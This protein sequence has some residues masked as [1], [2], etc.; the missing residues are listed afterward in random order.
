MVASVASGVY[1]SGKMIPPEKSTFS[2]W[3]WGSKAGATKYDGYDP[4]F[5]ALGIDSPCSWEVGVEGAVAPLGSC[6]SSMEEP[7]SNE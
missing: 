5:D 6:H 7:C 2:S 3:V 1:N 4:I